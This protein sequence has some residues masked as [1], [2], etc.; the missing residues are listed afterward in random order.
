MVLRLCPQTA[1][2]LLAVAEETGTAASSTQALLAV[3]YPLGGDYS[4][5]PGNLTQA[6]TKLFPAVSSHRTEIQTSLSEGTHSIIPARHVTQC[7]E[8]NPPLGRDGIK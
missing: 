3:S 4:R 7:L 1:C 2:G 6:G 5:A 8:M